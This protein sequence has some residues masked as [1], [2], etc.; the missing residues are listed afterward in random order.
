MTD[1][2]QIPIPPGWTPGEAIINNTLN[3]VQTGVNAS[4]SAINTTRSALQ[5]AI[6]GA[7]AAN[8]NRLSNVQNNVLNSLNAT[9]NALNNNQIALASN[10][11]GSIN[12]NAAA[13]L[14]N[15]QNRTNDINANVAA[16]SVGINNNVTNTGNSVV[17]RI[18]TAIDNAK[19]VLSG[20]VNAQ[21][22]GLAGLIA[23]LSTQVAGIANSI[24][25]AISGFLQNLL[26]TLQQL[27][28]IAGH[29]ASEVGED[30]GNW[31]GDRA[32]F[33]TSEINKRFAD[34]NSVIDK[35]KAN[36]YHSWDEFES[37]LNH[38]SI[39]TGLL[40][41]IFN[42]VQF[43]PL[44][45]QISQLTQKP[46]I[47]NLAH[48]A[49]EKARST[50]ISP[51]DALALM[52][53]KALNT[54][55]FK[56]ILAKQGYTD[57]D[58]ISLGALA[59]KTF[60]ENTIR[61]LFL[62]GIITDETHKGLLSELGYNDA[63]IH[64]VS[65]LYEVL[66]NVSDLVRFAVREVYSPDITAKY[67]QFEDFPQRFAQEAAKQGLS[68]EQ[69]KN[70]WAAHWE[71]PS[72]NMGYDMLHRGIISQDELAT[73]LRTLDVMPFWRDKLI[74]LSYSPLTRVDIRRLYKEG[75]LT[76]TQVKQSYKEIGYDEQKA[77]WLT[78]FTIKGGV[79]TSEDGQD[80]IKDLSQTAL[81]AA[82][83]R[84]HLTRS[85]TKQDLINL[86][87][88]ANEAEILLGIADYDEHQRL[89]PDR[90]LQHNEKLL[91]YTIRAYQKSNISQSDALEFL[92]EAGLTAQE[93]Q[94]E[95]DFAL[96]EYHI[97][98]QADI[99]N[100]VKHL[101]LE[102]LLDNNGVQAKL[103]ALD[104]STPEITQIISE[105][106]IAKSLNLRKPTLAQ[107]KKLY[108]K[109]IIDEPTYRTELSNFGYSDY[110]V[111]LLMQLEDISTSE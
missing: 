57:Q 24:P 95:L 13:I 99:T 3:N 42:L 85:Q 73:L 40:Q 103:N 51:P 10:V 32:N 110:Y 91:S 33:A 20:V 14:L 61:A 94:T 56:E 37:D 111:D 70:Y 81:I 26:T 66:P 72:I 87:Y 12:S 108:E 35:V 106:Q 75:I 100:Q 15:L 28:Y 22:G 78:Q 23:N 97:Q 89:H 55:Q 29:V 2:G 79:I 104:F 50:L 62:R 5:S 67:G 59:L 60:D 27:V 101:Y 96:L 17:S 77:N 71:L 7:A 21:T 109:S 105:L 86:G 63:T 6:D 74:K 52:Q 41:G 98:F 82:Y 53:R 31:I 80:K 69:A 83:K 9:A 90:S 39:N 34:L 93:A 102:G 36:R 92:Q 25:D 84:G 54:I 44:V 30:I 76:E 8:A 1:T 11:M 48:L 49:D 88:D 18:Q 68:N 46:F 4:I 64:L 43:I 47:D 16:S 65:Q 45:I 19:S 58:I 107:F 38:L